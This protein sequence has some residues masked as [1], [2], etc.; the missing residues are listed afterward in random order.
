MVTCTVSLGT[1]GY[2]IQVGRGLLARVAWQSLAT[3]GKSFLV[4]DE[5]LPE[6]L[7][8]SLQGGLEAAG[9]KVTFATVPRGES[10]KTLEQAARLYQLLAEAEA[11][12]DTLVVAVGGGAASDLVGFVAATYA[13][14]LPWVVLPT[15]LLA[16]VDAAIG[17]KTGVNLA[18]GKNLVGAFHQPKAVFADLDTL[19]TLP[20]REYRSGLAEVVKYG[21]SLD[22][23][24]FA[25]LERAGAR[26]LDPADALLEPAVVRCVELKAGIIAA[27]EFET[28][29]QRVMLNFGHTFAHAFETVAG[30]GDWLHGEAVAVGMVAACRLAERLQQRAMSPS[31]R[32]IGLLRELRLPLQPES[33]WSAADLL[34]VMKRDKKTARGK[35]RFLLPVELGSVQL[36]EVEEGEVA[37]VLL[38][39]GCQP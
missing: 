24:F 39:L 16:M 15:T 4:A 12:R 1:R 11:G 13:R 18:A 31:D 10:A 9:Q 8:A 26:L 6:T 2:P 33:H 30:H 20:V 21:A 5:A 37:A 38:G 27:D 35:L 3:S 19:A 7:L 23:A 22:T 29:A 14:G 34:R 32:L 25:E 17:G 36:V 28:Q